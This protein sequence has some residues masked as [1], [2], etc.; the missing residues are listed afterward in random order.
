M[1]DGDGFTPP[2]TDCRLTRRITRVMLACPVLKERLGAEI[3]MGRQVSETF[4]KAD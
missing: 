2:N 1:Q 4:P 3:W